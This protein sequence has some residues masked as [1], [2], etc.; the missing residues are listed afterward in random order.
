MAIDNINDGVG[1]K[2][3]EALKKQAEIIDT[4]ADAE[5]FSFETYPEVLM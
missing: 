2:I 1:K 5:V 3:V 4:P